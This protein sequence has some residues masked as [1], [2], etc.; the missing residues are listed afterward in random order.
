M[1]EEAGKGA[2][3]SILGT[4]QSLI[5]VVSAIVGV[6]A[7]VHAM[8]S[9]S[10]ADAAVRE[11]QRLKQDLEVRANERAQRETE[12]KFDSV[13]YDAVVNVLEI[14]RQRVAPEVA[15]KRERAVMALIAATATSPMKLALFEV[16]RTG[17]NV[18]PNVRSDADAAADVLRTAGSIETETIVQEP[19]NPTA[20]GGAAS[21]KELDGYRV[22][23]FYC[24]NPAQPESTTRRAVL[25]AELVKEM[26]GNPDYSKIRWETKL[27]PD[28]LNS[29]PG[30][31]ITTNQIRFNPQDG[32]NAS[33]VALLNV[34]ASSNTLRDH[35]SA[36][37]RHVA[38]QRTPQYLSFFLC[39]IDL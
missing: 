16:I 14:D 12:A 22:V 8:T 32:E 11:T 39:G 17:T 37:E 31:K 2:R 19:L 24:Q 20:A 23:V 25:A 7:A 27:M 34:L 6:I 36:I 15:E 35:K 28:V 33:S 30:Y 13:A 5:A 4:A 3:P 18:S 29:A 26:S 21:A 38:N 1:V 10:E 9:K